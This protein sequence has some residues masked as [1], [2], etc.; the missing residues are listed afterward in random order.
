MTKKILF[1]PQ[2]KNWEN[3]YHKGFETCECLS[4]LLC[5]RFPLIKTFKLTYW[6]L[7]ASNSSRMCRH[8][9]FGMDILNKPNF[10]L[11]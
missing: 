10:P 8:M 3:N 1:F 4:Q 9:E 6:W 5:E 11:R 2:I 7:Y